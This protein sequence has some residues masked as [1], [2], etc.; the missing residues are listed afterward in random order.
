M[1]EDARVWRS[2][3]FSTHPVPA[4]RG[5]SDVVDRRYWL[6]RWVP[7]T[8]QVSL[9]STYRKTVCF[10]AGCGDTGLAYDISDKTRTAEGE[11]RGIPERHY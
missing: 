5:W 4:V 7:S 2:V 6:R 9:Y 1:Q 8:L 3:N 10:K 11:Q